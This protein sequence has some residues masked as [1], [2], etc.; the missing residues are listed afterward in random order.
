[1]GENFKLIA[2]TRGNVDAIPAFRD[3]DRAHTL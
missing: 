2:L 1:M 3:I